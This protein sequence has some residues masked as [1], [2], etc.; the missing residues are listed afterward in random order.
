VGK[1]GK[2]NQRMKITGLTTCVGDTYAQYLKRA[3]PRWLDSLDSL[4]VVTDYE[5]FQHNREIFST[6]H[7]LVSEIFT[8]HGASFNKGGALSQGFAHA[9][10]KDWVLNF[11]SDICPPKNWREIVESFPLEHHK[12]YGSSH[13]YGEN[14]LLIPDSDFP[15][16]WGFFHLWHISDPHSWNR[17]VFDS[18]CGHAGN[19]DHSFMLQWPE[20]ER[21]DF[22]PKLKLTHQGEP[23]Q[24]WFG[25]DPKNEKKMTNLFMLGLWDAWQTRAGHVKTPEPE[26]IEIDGNLPIAAILVELE[27]Y[28]DPDPFRYKVTVK[29]CP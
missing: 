1:R 19:Y 26:K 24:R 4:L 16:V 7:T 27:R 13:R 29:G 5:T 10:P 18:T 2:S 8:Q 11:D 9:R 20:R 23:R 3:L 14:H 15:N 21:V 25:R 17:P 28:T 12:L 22:W 6:R